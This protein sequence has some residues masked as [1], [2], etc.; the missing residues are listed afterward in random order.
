MSLMLQRVYA[1]K[2]N[3]PLR[4]VYITLGW[5][6]LVTGIIGIF[7]PIL[8]TA[9]FIILAAFFF[10]RGSE[11]WHRWLL[12]NKRFGPMIRNW[13]AG[14]SISKGAKIMALVTMVAGGTGT[15]FIQ[16]IPLWVR[17]SQDIVLVLV[18]IYII[19]RPTAA[20]VAKKE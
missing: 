9:P 11:R 12:A 7:L 15:F 4:Y 8:P 17:V 14:H 1:E 20:P 5:I 13:E 2:V 3:L 16:S 18:G 19:T 6:S 10:S